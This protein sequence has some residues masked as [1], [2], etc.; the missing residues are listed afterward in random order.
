MHNRRL[1]RILIYFMIFAS[2]GGAIFYWGVL[3]LSWFRIIIGAIFI[4]GASIRLINEL[5]FRKELDSWLKRNYNKSILFY[6]A[7][8]KIQNEVKS[9]IIPFIN[10]SIYQVYYEGPK[11][12]GDLKMRHVI[13]LMNIDKRI[14][15]HNPSI[16]KVKEKSLEVISLKEFVSDNIDDKLATALIKKINECT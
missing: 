15:L 10:S 8:Q 9:K 14:Q 5:H 3:N 6:P 4:L 1:A 7:K 13:E 2:I 11:I 12:S 16:I